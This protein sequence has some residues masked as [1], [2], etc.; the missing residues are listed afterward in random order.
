M[1]NSNQDQIDRIVNN[2]TQKFNS[3]PKQASSVP[4]ESEVNNI[5]KELDP[6]Q[7]NKIK[8]ILKDPETTKKLLQ[9]PQ[10]QALIKKFGDKNNK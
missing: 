9:T 1:N 6:Q 5:L 8:S 2:L 10:A 3:N 4:S 7:A